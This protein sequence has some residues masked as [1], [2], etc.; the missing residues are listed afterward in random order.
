MIKVGAAENSGAPVIEAKAFVK[1]L[2]GVLPADSSTVRLG[3][4]LE[5]EILRELEGN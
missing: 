5:L 3:A 2:M 4:N 1:L